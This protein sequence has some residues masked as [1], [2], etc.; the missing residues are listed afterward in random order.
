MTSYRDETAHLK[1]PK[2]INFEFYERK[3]KDTDEKI[4]KE[5]QKIKMKIEG[6]ER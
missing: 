6:N 4:S 3:E 1:N 2:I 5:Y